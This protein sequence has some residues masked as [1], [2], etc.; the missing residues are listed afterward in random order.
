[1]ASPKANAITKDI[2]P[3]FSTYFMKTRRRHN[4]RIIFVRHGHPDYVKDCLT[5]L[6]HLHA[7]AAAERL[8]EETIHKAFSSSCGRARETAEHIMAGRGLPLT[9]CHFI[10]ELDWGSYNGEKLPYNGHPWNTANDMVSHAESISNPAWADEKPFCG[11]R[12]R[13]CV[14][15]VAKGTDEW[16]S[17]LGYEREGDFYRVKKASTE[18]ILMTS[19]AGA[20]SAVFA[21]M[22]NLPFP[23][24]CVAI[25]PRFTAITI[26]SFKGEEGA[27]VSPQ[28][29]LVNDARHIT[30]INDPDIKGN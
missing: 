5:P 9:L 10:R 13:N 24:V 14:A 1:M 21:H 26:V 27:L 8:R 3:Y 23:L 19:H 4:M 11:N 7:E 16:L 18:N 22:F 28:F 25:E 17:S 6:G 15:S 30:G 12:V 2:L 29:E 20:S